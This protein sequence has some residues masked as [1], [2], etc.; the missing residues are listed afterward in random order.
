MATLLSNLLTAKEDKD[1][2]I[3]MGLFQTNEKVAIA[4]FEFTETVPI[5]TPIIMAELPYTSKL[6]RIDFQTDGALVA[7]VDF[8]FFPGDKIASDIV[9][10]DALGTLSTGQVIDAPFSNSTLRF[11]DLGLDTADKPLYELAGLA[12]EPDYS[13]LYIGITNTAEISTT[14]TVAIFF[15]YTE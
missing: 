6:T 7:T 10:G 12:D 3:D 9:P 5:N 2:Q 14:G 13:T 11:D 1:V 4:T 15:R 8:G